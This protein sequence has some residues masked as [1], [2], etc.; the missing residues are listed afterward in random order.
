MKSLFSSAIVFAFHERV[1]FREFIAGGL[2][3][4]NGKG[5]GTEKA[6]GG[7]MSAAPT[8]ILLL[9]LNNN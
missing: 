4:V 6:K 7:T 1:R 9:G 2:G 3:G 5:G 8:M